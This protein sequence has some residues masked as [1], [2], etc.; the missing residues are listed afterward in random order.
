M[1]LLII[2]V[3]IGFKA[4]FTVEQQSIAIVERFGK[5]IRTAMPGLNYKIPLI[6][7]VAGSVNLRVQQLN[8]PVET[9]SG[10]NVFVKVAVS[11]QYHV[12]ADKT[13]QAFYKLENPE[14]QI[15]A[16]VFDVVRARVPTMKLDDVFEK[17]DEIANAVKQELDELMSEL[18]Y[19][20]V[21]SLVTD[22][23]PDAKVKT[24]MN[25]INEAQR[26]RIA[27]NERGE[28]EK[29]LKVKQ[30]EAEA[31]SA[32]LQGQGMANQRKAI[33]EGL[34]TSVADFQNSISGL[35]APDV[36]NIVMLT[37]YFDTLKEIG[38][39]NKSNSVMI[40][41]SPSAVSDLTAQM[42][43]A[44]VSAEMLNKKT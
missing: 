36:M 35:S 15:T 17:K 5:F 21:K 29:I 26:M 20:I 41:H 13:F 23:D 14:Q 9:K 40:P 43:N 19:N 34:K 33:I 39:N 16:F 10:D 28:A 44:F 22:I 12:I 37:Q 31:E 25:E 24:A 8:V 38:A 6:D 32:A 11:V 42:R 30:A 4:F 2:A 3:L 18:G 27:A 7:R 1:I